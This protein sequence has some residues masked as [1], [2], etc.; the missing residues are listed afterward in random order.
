MTN[1][2]KLPLVGLGTCYCEF[3]KENPD[4]G[5]RQHRGGLRRLL[6]MELAMARCEF[7]RLKGYYETLDMTDPLYLAGVTTCVV[8]AL[9]RGD[10]KLFDRILKDLRHYPEVNRHPEARLGREITEAWIRQFLRVRRGHPEWMVR[11]DLTHIPEEWKRQ[12][13]YLCVKGMFARQEYG[14]AYAAAS[15]LLNFDSRKDTLSAFPMYERIVCGLSCLELGRREEA[16]SWFRQ[17]AEMCCPCGII[18]PFV[19]QVAWLGSVMED[20]IRGVAP[21]LVAKIRPIAPKFFANL[22]RFHNHFSGESRTTELTPREFYLEQQLV[23][24][25]S[26]KEIAAKLGVS[27]GRVNDLVR[28]VYKK[29]GVHGKADLKKL[30]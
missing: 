30:V 4:A 1:D 7:D 27:S 8:G 20:V 17:T 25:H 28:T 2:F 6:A 23:D 11:G 24:G 14:P 15:M 3:S 21:E 9:G 18:L 19:L 22:L 29:L 10:L 5:V 26:Y 13:A 16:F 12:G